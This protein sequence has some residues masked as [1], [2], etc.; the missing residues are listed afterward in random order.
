[1]GT[2]TEFLMHPLQVHSGDN[3]IYELERP[4]GRLGD[5]VGD[6]EFHPYGHFNEDLYEI[7]V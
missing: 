5:E 1:M 7:S 4:R 3:V 2:P 6:Q